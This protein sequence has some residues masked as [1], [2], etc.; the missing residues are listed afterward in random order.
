MILL[1]A[2]LILAGSADCS[3][4]RFREMR[5][6]RDHMFQ[7]MEQLNRQ[8]EKDGGKLTEQTAALQSDIREQQDLIYDWMPTGMRQRWLGD[9]K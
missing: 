3:R 7:Q 9:A 6:M 2:L 4:D 8:R 5:T 1:T